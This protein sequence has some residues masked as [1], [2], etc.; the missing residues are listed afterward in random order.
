MS[1][2]AF[3]DYTTV[4]GTNTFLGKGVTITPVSTG[5]TIIGQDSCTSLSTA[6][7]NT[8]IGNGA[9]VKGGYAT[10]IG[11][12][13][14]SNA[15]SATSKVILIG[16]DAKISATHTNVCV[17]GGQ[18]NNTSIVDYGRGHL[19]YMPIVVYS[20]SATLTAANVLGGL[21]IFNATV[22][23]T[24]T[25]PTMAAIFTAVRPFG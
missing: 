9:D 15:T 12:R 23:C 7:Y 24:A 18:T 1:S 16:T 10:I 11:N 25:F 20:A 5:C 14:V 6:S 13:A 22:S 19:F 4:Q 3:P 17:L 8:V 2:F 21:V